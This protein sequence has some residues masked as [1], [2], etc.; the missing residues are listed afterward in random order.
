MNKEIEINPC[1][2]QILWNILGDELTVRYPI[3]AFNIL[4]ARQVED[5]FK[6]KFTCRK[7]NFEE[8][9]MKFDEN[10]K[11]EV[12]VYNDFRDCLLGSGVLPYTNLKELR[13]KIIRRKKS[14]KKTYYCL[15]TNLLYTRFITCSALIKP[16]D[17]ILVDISKDEIEAKLN[18]KYNS[19]GNDEIKLLKDQSKYQKHLFEELRNKKIK[20]SRKASYMAK[21]E[22][23]DLIKGMSRVL[24]SGEKSTMDTSK[25]DMVIIQTLKKFE[26][27]NQVATVFLTSDDAIID[28]CDTENI[29]SFK[30]NTP[31]QMK[32][33]SCTFQQFIDLIFN[34]SVLW[35]FIKIK[36]VIVFGEFRVKTAHNPEM[37]KLQFLD[38][39]LYNEFV[40]D[41]ETCRELM[42]IQ[43]A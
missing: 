26:K 31:H 13:E 39:N 22:F 16:S 14:F 34:L 21:R 9:R 40:K 6:L 3:Y 43:M 30:L 12:P 18:R 29:E 8:E 35:G 15:D 28:L 41:L 4:T 24:E 27:E 1:E 2:L 17:V 42:K 32:I 33:S 37:L 10:V 19:R 20:Q 7:E 25:N 36:S 5:G 23:V 38:E 11:D